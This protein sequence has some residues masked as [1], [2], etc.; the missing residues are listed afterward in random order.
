MAQPDG[1]VP[2][3]ASPATNREWW[4]S[5]TPAAREEH[6]A[7]DPQ[8]IGALEGLPAATRDQANRAA[9]EHYI[10]QTQDPDAR[11]LRDSI[12]PTTGNARDRGYLL[13]FQPASPTDDTRA[14]AVVSLGSP[15]TAENT[16]VIVPGATNTLGSINHN[17]DSA[18]ALK[19]E[20]DVHSDPTSTSATI[21]WLGYDPPSSIIP[22]A[23]NRESAI[24][25]GESLNAFLNGLDIASTVRRSQRSTTVFGH[26]YG[27][28]VV[29]NAATGD[30]EFHASRIVISGSPGLGRH[31]KSV[32]DLNIPKDQVFVTASP[33]DIITYTPHVFHGT[34]PAHRDFGA[35][36]FSAGQGGHG[37]YFPQ[38]SAGMRNLRNI[39]TGRLNRVEFVPPRD[40]QGLTAVR[41]AA[42]LQAVQDRADAKRPTL[43]RERTSFHQRVEGSKVRQRPPRT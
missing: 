41:G 11:L 39:I 14:R 2:A 17:I 29:G 20:V 25:G 35:R 10:A 16:C 37:A 31:V 32:H 13:R 28:V 26:S 5:L 22:G 7:H 21:A 6:L 40:R 9:L 42:L 24:A 34:D 33:D 12:G 36:V 30:S 27:S 8:A 4:T 19:S 3:A 18:R 1:K 23:L 43:S 38:G 15:D